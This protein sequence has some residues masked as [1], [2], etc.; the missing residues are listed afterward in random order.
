MPRRARHYIPHLPYHLLQRGINR[1]PSMSSPTIIG[2]RV[3]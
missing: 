3:R 2:A 1:E